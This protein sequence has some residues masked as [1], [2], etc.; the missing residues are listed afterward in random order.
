MPSGKFRST[1][2]SQYDKVIV[3]EEKHEVQYES[4]TSEFY[5]SG[6]TFILK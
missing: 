5:D 4:L 6:F 2:N 1:L 3:S